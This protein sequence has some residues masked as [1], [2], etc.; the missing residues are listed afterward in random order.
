M[1]ERKSFIGPEGLNNERLWLTSEVAQMLRLTEETVGRA[2]RAGRIQA[3]KVGRGW[4]VPD[5]EA[6]RVIRQ[7]L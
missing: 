2:I 7:G 1:K 4:R 5:E 3:R 6:E